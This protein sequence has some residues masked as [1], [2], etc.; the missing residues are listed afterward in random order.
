LAHDGCG[1][2]SRENA[3]ARTETAIDHLQCAAAR[4]FEHILAIA[5]LESPGCGLGLL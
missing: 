1:S 5:A 2:W 3:L 4:Q